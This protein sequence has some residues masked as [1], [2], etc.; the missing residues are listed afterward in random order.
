MNKQKHW[1]HA[2]LGH[3][4]FEDD[5]VIPWGMATMVRYSIAAGKVCPL[6][7]ESLG[8]GVQS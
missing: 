8:L 2:A 1:G 5:S 3:Q 4:D 6:G 7:L